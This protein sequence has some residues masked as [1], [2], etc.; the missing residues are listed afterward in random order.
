MLVVFSHNEEHN[1]DMMG[2]IAIDKIVGLAAAKLFVLSK[3]SEIYAKVASKSA[4]DYISD[5]DV[6]FAAQKM[7][8]N[9]MNDSNSEICPMEK[10]ASRLTEQELLDQ[11]LANSH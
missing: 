3:V 7:V 1:Q 10:L 9:I 11:L 2:S 8:D 6:K 4:F 5:K